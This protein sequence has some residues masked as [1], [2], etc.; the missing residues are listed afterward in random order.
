MKDMGSIRGRVAKIKGSEVILLTREGEFVKGYK[1]AENIQIGDEIEIRAGSKTLTKALLPL[2]A[3]FVMA[4]FLISNIFG[5]NPAAAYITLDINPSM[6]VAVDKDLM[7]LEAKALNEDGEEVLNALTIEEDISAAELLQ[8]IV[9]KAAQM[10]FISPESDGV[11]LSVVK[12][13]G[14]ADV[15]MEEIEEETQDAVDE[16]LRETGVEADVVVVR[17]SAEER[18]KARELGLSTGKYVFMQKIEAAA[19][20]LGLQI[21]KEVNMAAMLQEKSIARFIKEDLGIEVP[22][23]FMRIIAHMNTNN[24]PAFKEKVKLAEELED[25]DDLARLAEEKEDVKKQIKEVKGRIKVNNLSAAEK[26]DLETQLQDLRRQL[27]Q[28]E[29]SEDSYWL[30]QGL[31]N[32][33]QGNANKNSEAAVG[34][35]EKKRNQMGKDKEKPSDSGG[36]QERDK[37]TKQDRKNGQDSEQGQKMLRNQQVNHGGENNT[38]SGIGLREERRRGHDMN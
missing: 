38:G 32:K 8:K 31:K 20:D 22:G 12:A 26:A 16:A 34:S 5:V 4:L 29:V 11:F 13:D 17:G 6:E 37:E 28:I 9:L 14:K 25:A 23:K 36:N 7:V 15:N 24:V 27:E 1:P 18:Q 2:A 3:C 35:G 10:G 21:D 19:E 33:G 30:Y